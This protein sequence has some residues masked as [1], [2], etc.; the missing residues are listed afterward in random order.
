MPTEFTPSD[1]SFSDREQ[2]AQSLRRL[3]VAVRCLEVALEDGQPLPPLWARA[4]I[5]KASLAVY[6]IAKISAPK[7]SRGARKKTKK[8][9]KKA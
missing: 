5:L 3:K 9:A 8:R 1:L 4:A 2:L 7:K 6:Q